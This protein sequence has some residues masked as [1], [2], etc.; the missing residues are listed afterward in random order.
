[1]KNMNTRQIALTI[2]EQLGGR[3]FIVMTGV[4]A[5]FSGIDVNG[6]AYLGFRFPMCQKANYCRVTL[7]PMDA[8]NIEFMRLTGKSAIPYKEVEGVYGDMLQSIFTDVTG[9]DTHL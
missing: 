4:N 5:L 7:T 8:Y 9:L 1:M 3:K 2:L 6:N